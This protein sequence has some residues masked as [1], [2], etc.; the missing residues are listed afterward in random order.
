MLLVD[1]VF[2]KRSIVRLAAVS[3]IGVGCVKSTTLEGFMVGCL[4]VLEMLDDFCGGA[5]TVVVEELE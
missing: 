4:V 1:D 5:D 3:V 2:R